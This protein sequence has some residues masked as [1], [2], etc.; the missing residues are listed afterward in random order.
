[1][2]GWLTLNGFVDAFLCKFELTHN[3]WMR[4][5]GIEEKLTQRRRG[6]VELGWRL[7]VYG[8]G[9][10]GVMG[11]FFWYEGVQLAG[12]GGGFLRK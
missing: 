4:E 9:R 2:I 10:G 11:T 6:K 1:M 12:G 8:K 5:I 3:V 7:V